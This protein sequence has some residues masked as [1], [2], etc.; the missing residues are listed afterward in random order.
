MLSATRLY[1]GPP[2]VYWTGPQL[3]P[4]LVFGASGLSIWLPIH[5]KLTM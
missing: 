2:G 5:Y 4:D 1:F 3:V